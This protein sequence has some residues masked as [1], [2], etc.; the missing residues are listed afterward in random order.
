VHCHEEEI[1]RPALQ[2][3]RDHADEIDAGANGPDLSSR[4]ELGQRRVSTA[5]VELFK[6]MGDP[7]LR[8]VEARI[9]VVDQQRLDAIEAEAVSL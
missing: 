4:L 7:L 5:G 2:E 9:K 8:L 3:A 6:P 1:D